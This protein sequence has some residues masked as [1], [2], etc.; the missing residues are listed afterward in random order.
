VAAAGRAGALYVIE[1][2]QDGMPR[3]ARYDTGC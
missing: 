2:E 1:M 3:L